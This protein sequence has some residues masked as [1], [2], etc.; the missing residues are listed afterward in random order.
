MQQLHKDYEHTE[1]LWYHLQETRMHTIKLSWLTN[2]FLARCLRIQAIQSKADKTSFAKAEQSHLPA[3]SV[4][5]TSASN[6]KTEHFNAYNVQIYI[7][8]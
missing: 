6:F 4:D 3:L 5:V 7:L 2:E 8:L 1:E